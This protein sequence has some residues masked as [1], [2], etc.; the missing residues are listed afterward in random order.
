MRYRAM[1]AQGDYTFGYGQANFYI[2]SPDAVAQL[3]LT[4]LRLLQG[5]W[6][7]DITAGTPYSTDVLGKTTVRQRDLAIRNA[8]INTQGVLSILSYSAVPADRQ[9]RVS[10]KIDTIYGTTTVT[11]SL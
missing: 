7:L 5:E 8:I 6:F 2:D 1:T 10:A 4:N 9:Y 11:A 3:V